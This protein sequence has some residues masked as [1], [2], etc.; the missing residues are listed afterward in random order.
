MTAVTL[1]IFVN[2]NEGK[3]TKLAF[4][5]KMK[6]L[7][8]PGLGLFLPAVVMLLLALQWSGKRN[9]W[10]SATIM[11]LIIGFV[12]MICLFAIW[13][14][15]QQDE[16]SIPPRIMGQRSV[17][18][19]AAIVFFGLRSV[20]IIGYYIPMWFQVIKG[21]S[22]VGSGIRFLPLVLGNFMGSILFGGLGVFDFSKIQC[23][24]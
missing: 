6:H 12:I 17:D 22:P 8:L 24:F 4:L 15:Y 1:T 13:E 5:Q 10:E 23:R 19:A 11:G 2:P 21:V 20:Q 18:S 9:S 16:A 7:D 3:H 14:W